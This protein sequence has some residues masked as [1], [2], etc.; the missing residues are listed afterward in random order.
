MGFIWRGRFVFASLEAW[1]ILQI[2]I[3]IESFHFWHELWKGSDSRC[4]GLVWLTR[5]CS[6]HPEGARGQLCL[7]QQGDPVGRPLRQ[8]LRARHPQHWPDRRRAAARAGGIQ[9]DR[10]HQLLRH[11]EAGGGHGIGLCVNFT[12]QRHCLHQIL[13][14]SFADPVKVFVRIRILMFNSTWIRFL[15]FNFKQFVFS[16]YNQ[17]TLARGCLDK[18]NKNN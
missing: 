11:A 17:C 2:L 16:F 15:H 7:R 12:A 14:S 13:G 3:L 9:G 5:C 6:L 4:D 10:L 8:P 18:V 1:E